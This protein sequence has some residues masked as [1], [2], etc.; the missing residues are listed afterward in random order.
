MWYKR[1]YI[2]FVAQG[3]SPDPSAGRIHLAFRL[4]IHHFSFGLRR[5]RHLGRNG[6]ITTLHYHPSLRW[7]LVV[8]FNSTLSY[9]MFSSWWWCLMNYYYWWTMVMQALPSPPAADSSWWLIVVVVSMLVGAGGVMFGWYVW[10][11]WWWCN[12]LINIL[13]LLQLTI[14]YTITYQQTWTIILYQ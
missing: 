11:W 6:N 13:T 3:H 8:S 2:V 9:N 12:Q 1:S 4:Y 10:W 7:C 14:L 5:R